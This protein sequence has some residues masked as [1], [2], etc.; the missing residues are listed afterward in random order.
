MKFLSW[1]YIYANYLILWGYTEHRE[2]SWANLAYIKA[3]QWK[4]PDRFLQAH[5]RKDEVWLYS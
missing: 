5:K 4:C 3:E 1:F 2:V